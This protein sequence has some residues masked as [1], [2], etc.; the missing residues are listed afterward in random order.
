VQWVLDQT[1]L[2]GDGTYFVVGHF[3]T[4]AADKSRTAVRLRN[5]NSVLTSDVVSIPHSDLPLDYVLGWS[6]RGSRYSLD[7]KLTHEQ[8]A[9]AHQHASQTIT[10]DLTAPSVQWQNRLQ[11]ASPAPRPESTEGARPSQLS[12]TSSHIRNINSCSSSSSSSRSS[13]SSSSAGPTLQIRTPAVSPEANAA[14]LER[15]RSELDNTNRA[16]KDSKSK[17]NAAIAAA[18]TGLEDTNEGLQAAYCSIDEAKTELSSSMQA[19]VQ[20][21]NAELRSIIDAESQELREE[22]SA[23]RQYLRETKSELRTMV[24]E[25]METQSQ[26]RATKAELGEA[27]M[28]ATEMRAQIEAKA[29]QQ[30]ELIVDLAKTKSELADVREECGQTKMLLTSLMAEVVTLKAESESTKATVGSVQTEIASQVGGL[31][32]KL[33]A[34]TGELKELRQILDQHED[35]KES[36]SVHHRQVAQD[37]SDLR[38]KADHHEVLLQ[39]GRKFQSDLHGRVKTVETEIFDIKDATRAL[40]DSCMTWEVVQEQAGRQIR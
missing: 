25:L 1:S 16:M 27:T 21:S 24:T 33:E 4:L 20:Q 6:V 3:T 40:Q 18:M 35:F 38:C 22:I 9:A 37:L 8:V 12:N 5:S 19:A 34:M 15:I 2:S 31:N 14:E 29:Q 36:S 11:L 39:D 13:G 17:F 32:S 23:A 10:I 7:L 30:E 26:L 28:A